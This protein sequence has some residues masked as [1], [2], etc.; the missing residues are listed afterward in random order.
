V[1]SLNISKL[2]VTG[3]DD[4]LQK[5]KFSKKSLQKYI[6]LFARK[7]SSGTVTKEQFIVDN[8][9]SIYGGSDKFWNE[10]YE[11]VFANSLRTSTDLQNHKTEKIGI[12]DYIIGLS[13]IKNASNVQ[14][15]QWAFK[16]FDKDGDGFLDAHEIKYITPIRWSLTIGSEEQNEQQRVQGIYQRM[17]LKEGDR[18]EFK[19]FLAAFE[20]DPLVLK[21]L[22][23]SLISSLSASDEKKFRI[24]THQVAGHKGKQ[25]ML[26]DETENT[27]LKP[28]NAHE[29]GFYE[30]LKG[31]IDTDKLFPSHFFPKCYG[32]IFIESSEKSKPEHYII[33]ENLTK[34]YKKPCIVDLK[35]GA[36]SMGT[37]PHAGIIKKFKQ[38]VV[39]NMT[40]SHTLGFRLAGMRVWQTDGT[41]TTKKMMKGERIRMDALKVFLQ[42]L[43]EMIKWFEVQT[44]FL[45]L[46]SSV[47][48][49]YDGEGEA[50]DCR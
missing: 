10:I 23:R 45:F 1:A 34:G 24:F 26:L 14:K 46:S 7:Y 47:L 33:L 36:N 40:T 37:D 6:D 9:K 17:G 41:W 27:I 19:Q 32:S 30:L 31:A 5:T 48:L 38:T 43:D 18:V 39:N 35:M 13:K 2:S 20:N 11:T 28:L 21:A 50:A 22:K 3:F 29:Y 25:S 12:R 44:K 49:I 42:K 4:L 16:L 15:V 8:K